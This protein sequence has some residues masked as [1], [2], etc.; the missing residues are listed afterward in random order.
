MGEEHPVGE[1]RC[2]GEEGDRAAAKEEPGEQ[3]QGGGHEDPEEDPGE[4]PGEGVL[5]DVDRR[6]AAI[7]REEE[8]VLA[9]RGRRIG[10]DVHGPRDR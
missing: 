6:G 1:E 3:V 8:G 5:P 9:V 7:G 10:L 4:A 2:G